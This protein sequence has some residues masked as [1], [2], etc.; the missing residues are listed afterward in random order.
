M[1]SKEKIEQLAKLKYSYE[2][3]IETN[4]IDDLRRCFIEAYNQC[5]EYMTKEILF[6]IDTYK[7]DILKL[8]KE[9]QDKELPIGLSARDKDDFSLITLTQIQTLQFVISNL[10]IGIL[11]DEIN[12]KAS[13]PFAVQKHLKQD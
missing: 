11:R 1:R 4:V 3:G 10:E 8:E 9:L 7:S 12:Y 6:L 5:Q 2:Y 13:G